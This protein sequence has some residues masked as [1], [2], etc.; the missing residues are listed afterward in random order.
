MGHGHRL[1]GNVVLGPLS[2]Q[3]YRFAWEEEYVLKDWVCT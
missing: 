1:E 3:S 2:P